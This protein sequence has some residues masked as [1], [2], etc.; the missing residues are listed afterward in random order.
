VA[1]RDA[2]LA[3]LRG[4]RGTT[5]VAPD[6]EDESGSEAFWRAWQGAGRQVRR[7]LLLRAETGR[8]WIAEQLRT[9]GASVDALAVYRRHPH[10]LD[11]DELARLDR[12]LQSDTRAVVVVSSSEAVDTL[13]DQVSGMPNAVGWLRRCTAVATHP[14]VAQRLRSAGFEHIAACDADDDAIVRKLE[15]IADRGAGSH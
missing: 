15:S 1:T 9:A 3:E 10:L 11:A 5:I 14:R 7:V 4:A 2:V 8:E 13:L 12:W 6:V